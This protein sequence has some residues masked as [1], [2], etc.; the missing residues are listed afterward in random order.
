MNRSAAILAAA[1]SIREGES[2][3]IVFCGRGTA[4]ARMAALRFMGSLRGL[5]PAHWDPEPVG[6]KNIEHPTSNT[7]RALPIRGVA[8]LSARAVNAQQAAAFHFCGALG[9]AM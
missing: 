5:L 8:H 2:N 6:C 7:E 1:R 4:A 9:W 3:S